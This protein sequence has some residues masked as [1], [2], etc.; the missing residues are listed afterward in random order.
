MLPQLLRSLLSHDII[1]YGQYEKCTYTDEVL[2][3]DFKLT[4]KGQLD[5]FEKWLGIFKVPKAVSEQPSEEH[6]VIYRRDMN[7]GNTDRTHEE[8]T[9]D[10]NHPGNGTAQD[11]KT[12]SDKETS[13]EIETTNNVAH[14]DLNESLADTESRYKQD[15]LNNSDIISLSKEPR[16]WTARRVDLIISPYDQ[17]FYAVVGWTG[18]KMFNRDLRWY[19]KKELG[20][21]LTSHGLYDS[22]KVI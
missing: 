4:M 8:E 1:L 11:I 13:K 22:N 7:G 2:S 6:K 19:A 21:K 15:K 14:R 17:Y 16:K 5:H 12:A 10:L 18:N 9:G 3:K 20:M